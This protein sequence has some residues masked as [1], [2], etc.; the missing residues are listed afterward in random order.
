M[1]AAGCEDNQDVYRELVDLEIQSSFG[2]QGNRWLGDVSPE[3]LS[4]HARAML[5]DAKLA[6]EKRQAA[7]ARIPKHLLYTKGWPTCIPTWAEAS[8]SLRYAARL[9]A[10]WESKLSTPTRC[11]SDHA[12]RN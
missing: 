10:P 1:A 3:L 5:L 11:R 4:H 8:Y 2:F 12:T 6:A 9:P 7:E